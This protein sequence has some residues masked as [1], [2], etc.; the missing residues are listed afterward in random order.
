MEFAFPPAARP[1]GYDLRVGRD[2]FLTPVV[3]Y[4]YGA[5]RVDFEAD[6]SARRLFIILTHPA[7]LALLVMLTAQVPAPCP[8]AAIARD[9]RHRA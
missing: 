1:V 6:A 3:N 8:R 2:V 9:F 5:G 4:M 7:M